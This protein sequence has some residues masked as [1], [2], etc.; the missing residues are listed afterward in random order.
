MRGD[1]CDHLAPAVPESAGQQAGA[2]GASGDERKEDRTNGRGGA[3]DGAMAVEHPEAGGRASQQVL[4][5]FDTEQLRLIA[6]AAALMPIAGRSYAGK[7]GRPTSAVQHVMWNSLKV[8]C[9]CTPEKTLG[10]TSPVCPQMPNKDT[11]AVERLHTGVLGLLRLLK[12]P[13]VVATGLLLREIKD[14]WPLALHVAHAFRVSELGG[15]VDGGSI[16][17]VV[18]EARAEVAALADKIRDW[19]LT[20]IWERKPL[21]SVRVACGIDLPRCFR[22]HLGCAGQ[23]RDGTGSE[24]F[25]CWA[26]AEGAS[27]VSDRASNGFAR[28]LPQVLAQ[29]SHRSQEIA[30]VAI[31]GTTDSPAPHHTYS[32]AYVSWLGEFSAWSWLS[33]ALLSSTW[34]SPFSTS[35][36]T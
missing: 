23:G 30:T 32:I 13:E 18:A 1:V 16:E 25:P 33:G 2:G 35:P 7:K 11:N 8:R 10:L 17:A 14:M 36:R 19:E 12:E 20:R 27:Q 34:G 6:L 3:V 5:A 29:S 9:R 15:V 31:V 24:R 28:R 26:T 22:D 21:V 4:E